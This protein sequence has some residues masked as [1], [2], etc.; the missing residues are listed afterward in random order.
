MDMKV[1]FNLFMI[2][3]LMLLAAAAVTMV[4]LVYRYITGM[5]AQGFFGGKKKD[6]TE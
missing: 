3:G 5:R 2:I 1:A 4:F 6:E